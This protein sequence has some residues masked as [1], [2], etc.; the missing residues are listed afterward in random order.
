MERINL[1]AI[2]YSW[3]CCSNVAFK[4]NNAISAAV[5]FGYQ[6]LHNIVWYWSFRFNF[7]TTRRILLQIAIPFYDTVAVALEQ[8]HFTFPR[9][10]SPDKGSTFYVNVMVILSVC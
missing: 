4:A 3:L 5:F 8:I 6:K 2:L 7:P 1:K 10:V 9:R